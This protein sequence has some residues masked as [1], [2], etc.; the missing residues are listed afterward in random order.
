MRSALLLAQLVVGAKGIDNAFRA[1]G[2]PV[3]MSSD[4]RPGER[5]FPGGH[6]SS[7]ISLNSEGTNVAYVYVPFDKDRNAR[8]ILAAPVQLSY[9]KP[10]GYCVIALRHK[11]A[12]HRLFGAHA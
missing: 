11:P 1:P 4:G 9:S 6:R 5:G 7:R 2:W 10:A 8:L 12:V 3:N